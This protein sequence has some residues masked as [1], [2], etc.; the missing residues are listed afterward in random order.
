MTEICA[1]L[2]SVLVWFHQQLR[3]R[4]EERRHWERARRRKKRML[5]H[6]RIDNCLFI[7]GSSSSCCY[8]RH[9]IDSSSLSQL[10]RFAFPPIDS[11]WLVL[12]ETANFGRFPT[13]IDAGIEREILLFQATSLVKQLKNKIVMKIF[14]SPRAPGT[15]P[16]VRWTRNFLPSSL[17]PLAVARFSSCLW[18]RWAAS[19][20][21]FP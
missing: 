19:I 8:C 10:V 5:R 15:R 2:S 7:S 16:F 12:F 4:A 21:M 20:V 18:I 3:A 1:D 14:A 9:R 11:S 17:N 13:H 6:S